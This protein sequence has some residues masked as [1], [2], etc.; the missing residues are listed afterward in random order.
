MTY[1]KRWHGLYLVLESSQHCIKLNK[2]YLKRPTLHW[3]SK[4]IVGYISKAG[5]QV[6][7]NNCLCKF[8]SWTQWLS[9]TLP[10]VVSVIT[11][12]AWYRMTSISIINRWV[13]GWME[14]ILKWKRAYFDVHIFLHFDHFELIH[15]FLYSQFW[16]LFHRHA[17]KVYLGNSVQK[18]TTNLTSR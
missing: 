8:S 6:T 5:H 11:R 2:Y 3:F 17:Y 9:F 4:W 10:F 1:H 7:A 12:M 15:S 16:V 18:W 13:G 14:A